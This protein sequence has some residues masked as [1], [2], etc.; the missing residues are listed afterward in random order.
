MFEEIYREARQRIVG[1]T[2]GLSAEELS[3]TVPA[4]PE[5]T[6]HQLLAHLSGAASDLAGGRMDGAPSDE[7]T[8]RHVAERA[9]VPA[10]DLLE[11][12]NASGDRIAEMARIPYQLALD[13]LTH[14]ADLRAA[15]RRERLPD[16]AWQPTL[17]WITPRRLAGVAVKTELGVIGDG[18][19]TLETDGYELWRAFFGRRS[20]RQV[21]SWGW[22]DPSPVDQLPFFPFRDT[23]LVE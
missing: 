7:W 4:C 15:L 12:W 23:D 1:L 20:R 19:I 13:A 21:E 18:P 17:V 14:E 11:Q 3:R 6:V 16:S 9:D 2:M 5:W 22:S 8:A 10:D